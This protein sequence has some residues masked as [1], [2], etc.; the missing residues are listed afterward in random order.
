MN[1]LYVG[2]KSPMQRCFF[3]NSTDDLLPVLISTKKLSSLW[4][5][6]S[7]QAKIFSGSTQS[8]VGKKKSVS[9]IAIIFLS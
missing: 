5:C 3:K 7:F 6:T 2:N 1:I 4:N 8:M 9:K